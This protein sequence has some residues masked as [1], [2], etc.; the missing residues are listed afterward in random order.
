MDFSTDSLRDS[1]L[2]INHTTNQISTHNSSNSAS[3]IAALAKVA[4]AA[5][6][7]S[8]YSIN[9]RKR[10]RQDIDSDKLASESSS[11]VDGDGHQHRRNSSTSS[12]GYSV[13]TDAKR[14]RGHKNIKLRLSYRFLSLIML[15]SLEP[16]VMVEFF[17]FYCAALKT[18]G[19][20][21]E[22]STH[23]GQMTSRND[24]CDA[25]RGYG[26]FLCCESC[27]RAFHFSCLNPPLDIDEAPEEAHWY[28]NA[29]KSRK[30]PP[31]KSNVPLF[32][33]LIDLL[34]RSNPISFQ[35][36]DEIKQRFSG[37]ST[38]PHSGDYIDTK[39]LK[40][41]KSS[42]S[43]QPL[44]IDYARIYGDDNK[45]IL[46]FKCGFSARRGKIIGCD[47]CPLYW[48]WDCLDPPLVHPPPVNRKWMCPAHASH[49][50]P[51]IRKF[52]DQPYL[53]IFPNA[54]FNFNSDPSSSSSYPSLNTYCVPPN[55]GDIDIALEPK[56]VLEIGDAFVVDGTTYR[57]PEK[58]VKLSFLSK[59]RGS[60]MVPLPSSDSIDSTIKH[61]TTD[62]PTTDE[63]QTWLSS[64]AMF[65]QELAQYLCQL[66]P[67]Q[68]SQVTSSDTPIPSLPPPGDHD[69]PF[70]LSTGSVDG[71]STLCNIAK[72]VDR[73]HKSSCQSLS[74]FDTHTD[75]PS[76]SH[77]S[78]PPSVTVTSSTDSHLSQ[79]STAINREPSPTRP[80]VSS[81]IVDVPPLSAPLSSQPNIASSSPNILGPSLERRKLIVKLTPLSPGTPSSPNSNRESR[82]KEKKGK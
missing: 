16:L 80:S 14:R 9:S 46:C 70:A 81:K 25:C 62:P 61:D 6:I 20:Q 27:P 3:A 68:E 28:C 43:G 65:Q 63:I 40:I 73:A 74:S 78:P 39:D 54:S 34:N 77:P 1:L 13:S 50:M 10:S 2:S 22:M 71:L 37:V 66:H 42:R 32:G 47:H 15:V 30:I 64:L 31:Q 12:K 45:I 49:D 57:L 51:K 36:T 55:F 56:K 21:G 53:D 60:E 35:L 23:C 26:R 82:S 38:N 58:S 52:A 17:M 72:G 5:G 18:T 8:L 59:V 11:S 33:P 24:Q 19:G 75:T 4:S 41:P 69:I 79:S 48:H 67:T 7:N 29:C 76:S 44:E